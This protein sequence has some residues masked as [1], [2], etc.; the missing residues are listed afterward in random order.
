MSRGGASAGTIPVQ[1][2]E[3]WYLMVTNESMWSSGSTCSPGRSCD[4][5]V[6]VYPALQ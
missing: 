6:K 1:P 3:T 2:G 4:I 5:G